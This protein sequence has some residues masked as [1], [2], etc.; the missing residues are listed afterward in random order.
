MLFLGGGDEIRSLSIVLCDEII[1][2]PPQTVTFFSKVNLVASQT[3]L[4]PAPSMRIR[5]RLPKIMQIHAD[6][7]PDLQYL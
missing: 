1:P 3:D 6:L 5:T 4:D 2:P 7:Y